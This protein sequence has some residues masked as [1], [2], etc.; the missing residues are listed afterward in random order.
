MG[1]LSYRGGAFLF[2]VGMSECCLWSETLPRLLRI[3]VH[4]EMCGRND[5]EPNDNRSAVNSA[6]MKTIIT[7]SYF[8][9]L[10]HVNLFSDRLSLCSGSCGQEGFYKG[11]KP[12]SGCT[13]V[14]G[15]SE[16]SAWQVAC[17]KANNTMKACITCSKQ[18]LARLQP[19]SWSAPATG[20]TVADSR[21]WIQ[22]LFSF[23]AI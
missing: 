3:H 13:C 6:D 7:E 21:N 17:F 23:L 15:V 8:R 12:S 16:V 2:P 5:F 22:T 18:Q 1:H 14:R 19:V 9:I 20:W 10:R 4:V 11:R